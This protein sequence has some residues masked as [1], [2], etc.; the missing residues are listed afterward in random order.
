M[1][2][3]ENMQICIIC[4][5]VNK[6][7]DKVCSNCCMYLPAGSD[8]VTDFKSFIRVVENGQLVNA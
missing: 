1:E 6:S 8:D 5:T 7:N 3:K 2:S 4:G